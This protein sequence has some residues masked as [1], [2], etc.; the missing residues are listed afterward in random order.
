MLKKWDGK[1][2]FGVDPY[3]AYDNMDPA[4][5]GDR[6]QDLSNAIKKLEPF[7]DRFRLLH[8]TSEEAINNFE[9]L[10]LDFVYVDGCH[11]PENVK[12]DMNWWKK[13]RVG[14]ILAGH[15][16]QSST[17]PGMGWDKFIRPI[18]NNFADSIGEPVYIIGE[19]NLRNWSYYIEKNNV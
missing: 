5:R 8:C 9:D 1:T 7:G 19:G 6:E 12:H 16:I 13:L 14:G 10:S 17:K 11:Q 3:V 4:S 18:V 15:D 2:W